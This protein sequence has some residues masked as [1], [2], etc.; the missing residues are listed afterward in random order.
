MEKQKVNP[1]HQA[2]VI[3]GI[4]ALVSVFF[5]WP[6]P[7]HPLREGE[8]YLKIGDVG[9]MT[10]IARTNEAR[11]NGLSNRE[12]LCKEC[13]MA[14]VFDTPGQYGVWMKDMRFPLD[15]LWVRNGKV[16][17]KEGNVSEQRKDVMKPNVDAELVIE[18][19]PN[20]ETKV[21]DEVQMDQ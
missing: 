4:L 5:F 17:H 8:V 11:A 7:L 10:Q 14:F 13:A 2:L 12:S 1:K 21:G 20:S 9:Y 16:V 6:K 19:N 18:T 15:I 3:L